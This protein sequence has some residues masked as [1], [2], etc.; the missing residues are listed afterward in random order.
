MTDLPLPKQKAKQASHMASGQALGSNVVPAALEYWC[1]AC[2]EPCNLAD[3]TPVVG[4]D[5]T[6]RLELCCKS[7]KRNM[8]RRVKGRE[9]KDEL[10]QFW[11]SVV[12]DPEKYAAWARAQKKRPKNKKGTDASYMVIDDEIS[13]I[14]FSKKQRTEFYSFATL[15][16]E[17]PS[18]TTEEL[19][20][21]WQRR[22][23]AATEQIDVDGV[24][25]IAKPRVI[26]LDDVQMRSRQSTVRS[27]Q[28]VAD[29]DTLRSALSNA[30]VGQQK[31]SSSMK[32]VFPRRAMV[33]PDFALTANSES[34]AAELKP[35]VESAI[36][37]AQFDSMVAQ[38]LTKKQVE[39][40]DQ[41][42]E[43]IEDLKACG[44]TPRSAK[45]QKRESEEGTDATEE[46]SGSVISRVAA[47]Q[48]T[49]IERKAKLEAH[50]LRLLQEIVDPELKTE[51]LSA[52]LKITAEEDYDKYREEAKKKAQEFKKKSDE[53]ISTFGSVIAV[54]KLKCAAELKAYIEKMDTAYKLFWGREGHQVEFRTVL[55]NWKNFAGNL[56]KDWAKWE[57]SKTRASQTK[58][59]AAAVP[60]EEE[61]HKMA[62]GM[63]TMLK[64]K[65]GLETTGCSDDATEFPRKPYFTNKHE[66]MFK[67]FTDLPGYKLFSRYAQSSMGKNDV[68]EWTA[69]ITNKKFAEQTVKAFG[70]NKLPK[71]IA[72]GNFQLR[73]DGSS[74]GLLDMLQGWQITYLEEKHSSVNVTAFCC[75]EVRLHLEGEYALIGI[76]FD[77]LI[78]TNIAEKIA[79]LGEISATDILSAA[80]SLG[81]FYMKVVPGT[82]LA[83]PCGYVLATVTSESAAL[84]P[85]FIRY[86]VYQEEDKSKVK[87]MITDLVQCHSFLEASDYASVLKFVSV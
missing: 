6:C 5:P 19:T 35:M 16:D 52:E 57:A 58:I 11:K 2:E 62:Q 33:V 78:G 32:N 69:Q 37:N 21:L 28:V 63:R 14:S 26:M 81:G 75:A 74:E 30:R 13:S 67:G 51:H 64:D 73:V 49:M 44:A 22:V 38:A 79:H 72:Q 24:L 84:N 47:Y 42:K 27:S 41:R 34:S 10:R 1:Q 25:H 80:R 43:E 8:E 18:M 39:E 70:G 82:V 77:Q 55:K 60:E 46:S 50:H 68:K 48:A 65:D 59:R 4:N 83:I 20:A 61:E 76:A 54:E 40:E 9:D 53:F 23:A 71:V 12:S 31:F 17:N 86:G 56:K 7:N 45:K 87:S 66:E 3:S 36:A 29:A 15:E 85:A